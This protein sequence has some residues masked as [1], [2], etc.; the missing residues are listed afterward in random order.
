MSFEEMTCKEFVSELSSK[1]P[2][3]GG[4]GASALAG[5]VGM[6]LSNMVASLTIGK[7]KYMDVE[8][9]MILLKKRGVELQE[10]LLRMADRDAEVF[11]PL[12]RAYGLPKNTQEEREY[13][14]RVM[15]AA[16]KEAASVPLEI[17]ELCCQAIDL[18][19]EASKKG[20]RIAISDAG[21]SAALLGAA[22]RGAALNIFIN[23]KSMADTEYAE[24]LNARAEELIR[25]YGTKADSVYQRVSDG[26]KGGI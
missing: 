16:L 17:M 11:E 15:E 7:K 21:V 23:T 20:S 26:L 19:E 24:K 9:D 3:P 6:A 1:S 2:V 4:G 25:E 18:A 10:S 12:S 14:S 5:A 13:K 8:E 22:L